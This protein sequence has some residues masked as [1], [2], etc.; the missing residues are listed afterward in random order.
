M[1]PHEGL[2][3]KDVIDIG[4]G[5]GEVAV[6]GLARSGVAVARLLVRGGARV[7]ASDASSTD[8]TNRAA[9]ELR[10]VGVDADA[11]RHDLDR[12]ARAALVVASPGVPPDSPPLARARSAQR[13]VVSEVEVA[14]AALPAT[15]LLAVTG[16][17][18]K[19]TVTALVDHL[20]RSFGVDCVAAGNIGTALSEIAL[21]DVPPAMAV[22]ELSSFQLHDTPSLDPLA[23]V[24]TN[25]APD[26]LDR[27]ENVEQ[28]YADKMLLFRNASARSMWVSNADDMEVQRRVL[29]VPGRHLRFSLVD[30]RADAGPAHLPSGPRSAG[31][32]TS[33]GEWHVMDRARFATGDLPLMGRHNIANALAAA[34]V[35][36]AVLPEATPAFEERLR[37]GLRAFPGLPHRLQAVAEQDGVVWIDDS[38]ATNVSSA[39]VAIE[40]MTRPT[41]VLLGGLHKGEPYTALIGALQKHARLVIA[42]GKAAATIAADLEG[43]VP[44]ARLGSSFEDVI[45][46]ARTA[47]MPGDAVLLAPACSSF[48][49]FTD[50]EERGAR[51][52]ALARAR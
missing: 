2:R 8:A 28:Y 14:I 18:G 4:Q 48:D 31:A 11:G 39:L 32:G 24:L 1:T 9:T 49:M 23:G 33:A 20:L 22:A 5:A 3:R 19:S 27:Y 46:H 26:H 29:D 21:R 45:A 36:S 13:R 6:I 16:T 30:S 37:E 41:V 50:Y 35:V 25:L 52:A 51:F 43:R 40:A 7:Y 15:R 47:A 10:A 17:N 34:L 44:L 12:I 42:Y 38:K